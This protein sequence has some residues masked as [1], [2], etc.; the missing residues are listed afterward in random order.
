MKIEDIYEKLANTFM[1]DMS[2]SNQTAGKIHVYTP[3]GEDG[4]WISKRKLN[5]GAYITIN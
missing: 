5:S 2:I 4:F 1:K 3:N